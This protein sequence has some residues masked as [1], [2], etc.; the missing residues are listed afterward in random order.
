MSRATQLSWRESD[1]FSFAHARE[2]MWS[3]EQRSV[4]GRGSRLYVTLR[5]A[6]AH[7]DGAD[8]DHGWHSTRAKAK[9]AAQ[10]AHRMLERLD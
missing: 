3:V 7:R 2:G 9:A 1:G 10:K 5:L 6:G 4:V 8:Q